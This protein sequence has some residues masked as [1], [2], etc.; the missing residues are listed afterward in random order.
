[1]M[2][3]ALLILAMATVPTPALPIAIEPR[4]LGCEARNLPDGKDR[5]CHVNV[6]SNTRIRACTLS[7]RSAGRCGAHP[8]NE[9]VAWIVATGTAQ[10]RIVKKKTDWA[11][12]VSI[13]VTKETRPGAGTC[14]LRVSI[15]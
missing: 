9:L 12:R 3:E 8:K 4:L 2:F 7:E 1:M 5:R 14:A 11:R 10:C 6:P 13:K 15:Q